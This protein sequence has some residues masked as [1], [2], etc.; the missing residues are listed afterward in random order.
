ML[1]MAAVAVIAAAAVCVA[2]GAAS[3]G[4]EP[5]PGGIEPKTLVAVC[6][7]LRGEFYEDPKSVHP[8]GCV[9]SDGEIACRES[10]ACSFRPLGDLPP[11]EETCRRVG[12]MYHVDVRIFL[13]VTEMYAVEVSCDDDLGDCSTS[14]AN[15]QPMPRPKL[16]SRPG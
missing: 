8:Y 4:E 10:T 13:C 14:I 7:Q 2:P 6:E 5:P 15:E 12:G 16:V 1:R 11:L 9:R 3:A